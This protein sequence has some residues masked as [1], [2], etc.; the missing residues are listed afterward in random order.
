MNK[1]PTEIKETPTKGRGRKPVVNT[2]RTIKGL[3]TDNATPYLL[4]LEYKSVFGR[5][6]FYG[7]NNNAKELIKFSGGASIDI[8]NVK[9]LKRLGF[10]VE[11]V[12]EDP[13]D[14]FK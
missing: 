6:L 11:V 8:E 5:R 9:M 3:V 10:S 12:T 1:K 4:Q 14:F 13:N 7:L 2:T